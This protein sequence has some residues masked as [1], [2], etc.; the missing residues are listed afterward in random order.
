MVKRY[1]T[2]RAIHKQLPAV[3]SSRLLKVVFRVLGFYIW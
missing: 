3:S 2:M 1:A